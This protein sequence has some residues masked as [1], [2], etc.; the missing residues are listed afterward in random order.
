MNRKVGRDSVE[1]WNP[2][3]PMNI[4]GLDGA[5]PYRLQ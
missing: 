2:F 1:P 3:G 5:S 4:S